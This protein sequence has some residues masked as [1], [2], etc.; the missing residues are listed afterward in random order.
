M[1]FCHDSRKICYTFTN[2]GLGYEFKVIDV[3]N[4]FIVCF[5][6]MILSFCFP[7]TAE[8]IKYYM[9]LGLNHQRNQISI[10]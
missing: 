8:V 3:K 2:L 4:D 1:S 5:V 6:Y 9:T 10:S 7:V